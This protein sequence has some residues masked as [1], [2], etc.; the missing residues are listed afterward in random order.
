[1]IGALIVLAALLILAANRRGGQQ[2][3]PTA[4]STPGTGAGS[5]SATLTPVTPPAGGE[6][7]SGFEAGVITSTTAPQPTAG[8]TPSETQGKVATSTRVPS[9]KPTRTPAPTV[10]P[11][12]SPAATARP[13]GRRFPPGG[14]LRRQCR[15]AGC[16]GLRSTGCLPRRVDTIRLIQQGG[17]FPYRQDG[18]VFQNREGVLPR[19][20][21]GYYHEYTVTTPGSPDRGAR[22]IVT[23]GRGE[24]YYTSD[25]YASFKQVVL[26]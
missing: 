15:A 21:S 22:R 1:M 25:H 11:A 26:P 10:K 3:L 24:M 18:V 19:K 6:P 14:P 12:R 13:T 23:G 4:P 17:P 16:R 5:V 20:A 8:L 2:A 9:L 7:T